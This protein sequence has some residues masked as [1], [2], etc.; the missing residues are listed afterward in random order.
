MLLEDKGKGDKKAG[1]QAQSHAASSAIPTQRLA[2]LWAAVS[3]LGALEKI[4]R[5]TMDRNYLTSVDSFAK[6]TSLKNL[7]MA[8]NAI[9][10]L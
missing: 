6:L 2:Q 10:K 4:D 9:A 8:N 7:S 5:L 1:L 3:A